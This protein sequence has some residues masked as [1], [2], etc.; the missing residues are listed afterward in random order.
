MASGQERLIESPTIFNLC[1]L[2]KLS[3]TP[4]LN[5]GDGLTYYTSLTSPGM[6]FDLNS[7]SSMEMSSAWVAAIPRMIMRRGAVT[8]PRRYSDSGMCVNFLK[9][10]AFEF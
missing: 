6:K 2:H 8:H 1:I 5:D 4:Y 3:L 7:I 9:C 10:L